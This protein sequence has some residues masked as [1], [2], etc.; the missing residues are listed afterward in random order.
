MFIQHNIEWHAIRSITSLERLWKKEKTF[1]FSVFNV[2]ICMHFE[3][4]VLHFHFV[5]GFQ[6]I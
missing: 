1:Y 2:I 6:I 5:L 4:A 3:Q